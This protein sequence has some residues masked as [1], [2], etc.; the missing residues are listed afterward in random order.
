MAFP[1]RNKK[2]IMVRRKDMP[3][4][5][6]IQDF[7]DATAGNIAMMFGLLMPILFMFVG[8]AVDFSRLN[9]VKADLVESL[10]AAGLAVARY[11]DMV[12]EPPELAGKTGADREAVL[13]D[14]G[15]KFFDENFRYHDEVI[16]LQVDFDLSTAT[17]EPTASGKIETL[18]LEA[19]FVLVN[20]MLGTPSPEGNFA[21]FDIGTDTEITRRGAGKLELALVLDQTG[22][23][24]GKID[25]EK[26]IDILKEAVD[27]LLQVLY[28]ENT[29][30][31]SVKVGV[32]PFNAY[33][34][35]GRS[36]AWQ[37]AWN[38]ADA[39]AT[40]HGAHFIH[41]I[42]DADH[43]GDGTPD[44]DYS[45]HII[46]THANNGERTY[47]G[48][49]KYLDVDTKVNHFTLYDSMS[50]VDWEG[51]VESRP[52]PLD[53]LDT[54]PGQAVAASTLSE[55]LAVPSA[56][57]EQNDRMRTAF[58]R[59]PLMSLSASEVGS[60]A[61]SRWVPFFHPDEPDCD[62]S[63]SNCNDNWS[64][65]TENYTL[66]GVSRAIQ[67]RGYMFD[68]PS[69]GGDDEGDYG[70]RNFVEDWGYIHR[71]SSIAGDPFGRYAEVVLAQRYVTSFSSGSLSNYWQG[72][73]ARFEELGITSRGSHEYRLRNSYVGMFDEATGKY[74]GK[75]DD[76][77]DVDESG[78]NGRNK[79]PNKSC[80]E[81]I[82]PLTNNRQDVEDHMDDIDPYGNTNSANGAVW[83]WRVVSPEA[84]FTE[85]EPYESGDW[86]KAVV[87]MTD[88]VNV[89]SSGG[90]THWE[91]SSST[92]G[93]AIEER[94]G[95]GV[96]RP[97]RG[98]G[99]FDSDRMAD[100]VDEKL[101]RV[102]RRMKQ[103]GILVYTIVFGL[104]D[105]NLEE[106][107]QTCATS[108]EEPY[109]FKAPTAEQLKTA[110]AD[111]AQDL[112]DLHVSR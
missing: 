70:N 20:N 63:G 4:L 43:D 97:A 46:D 40:Y 1:V 87:I 109:Y 65:R 100:H 56:G 83:G 42:K 26:K 61:N 57:E 112:V 90:D 51:C 86:Q 8:G 13:K 54:V 45:N 99:G 32:V 59:A 106:V 50:D 6:R 84:P 2:A 94:M 91:S 107:F 58:Q 11:D 102:C 25:G 93:Y 72:V 76:L 48:I 69:A 21:Y 24:S 12:P 73:K 38:D 39:E 47:D 14:F 19:G 41:A 22:S 68:G 98:G 29:T 15:K 67:T 17:I 60:V 78:A 104:N 88:G 64:W 110:F 81:E 105:S 27:N 10:D 89:I 23:M 62:Y 36:P 53:E 80:P 79:G 44:I 96:D 34:N 49:A 108:P 95:S 3:G 111:I 66:G 30:D 31:S 18:V 71:N 103:E 82:L 9:Q 16:D 85:G 37:N 28:G 77:Q 101:L 55:E 52:Y 75:Y 7:G 33:V 74:V 5:K 35:P 92:H